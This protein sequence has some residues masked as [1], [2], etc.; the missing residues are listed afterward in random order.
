MIDTRIAQDGFPRTTTPRMAW[1]EQASAPRYS[2]DAGG[3]AE[4][5]A[6]RRTSWKYRECG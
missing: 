5:S 2:T 1:F 4:R 3:T 6:R